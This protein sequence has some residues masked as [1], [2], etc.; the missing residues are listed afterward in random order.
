MALLSDVGKHLIKKMPFFNWP[1]FSSHRS[2]T[3][4][5]NWN[6]G[7]FDDSVSNAANSSKAVGFSSP[8]WRVRG[9]GGYQ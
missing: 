8:K 6:D 9:R 1:P 7:F 3:Y 2:P 5:E 4:V